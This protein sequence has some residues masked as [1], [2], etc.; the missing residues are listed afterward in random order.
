MKKIEN[1]LDLFENFQI[2]FDKFCIK[3]ITKF[4]ELSKYFD[5]TNLDKD[6]SPKITC[7]RKTVM[8]FDN[9]K[10]NETYLIDIVCNY[11]KDHKRLIDGNVDFIYIDDFLVRM[12]LFAKKAYE[13]NTQMDKS[14]F[15][16]NY[17][18]PGIMVIDPIENRID[19]FK[20][21]LFPFDL[22]QI[23]IIFSQ[24]TKIED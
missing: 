3:K 22:A 10:Y 2:L 17:L 15:E 18:N 6:R 21:D 11:L 23:R 4:E 24:N 13:Q 12:Y 8:V 9:E 19:F 16:K 1:Q 5:L 20:E 14:T 7:D